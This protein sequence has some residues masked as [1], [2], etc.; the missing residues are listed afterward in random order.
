[1]RPNYIA[2]SSPARFLPWNTNIYVQVKSL[3]SN[4]IWHVENTKSLCI[5]VCACVMILTKEKLDYFHSMSCACVIIISRNFE[6]FALC[7]AILSWDFLSIRDLQFSFLFH[8]VSFLRS[9]QTTSHSF[10]LA[11]TFRFWANRNQKKKNQNTHTKSSL[12]TFSVRSFWV[13]SCTVHGHHDRSFYRFVAK[14]NT[15]KPLFKSSTWKFFQMVFCCFLC[16]C[17][18]FF[19]FSLFFW[20]VHLILALF[21]MM[22]FTLL[23]KRIFAFI[24]RNNLI[25]FQH[26]RHHVMRVYRLYT[27]VLV[28]MSVP[29][30]GKKNTN[31]KK[32][33]VNSPVVKI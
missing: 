8:S 23:H 27:Y 5:C 6:F 24:Q 33:K 18:F 19:C 11:H 14:R 10:N 9:A 3:W 13:A 25:I 17:F 30:W 4:C 22:I 15:N 26:H 2:I 20:S 29:E 32:F 7:V 28:P 16:F 1:M 21:F 12:K 31:A